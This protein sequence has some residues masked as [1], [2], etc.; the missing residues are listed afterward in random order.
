MVAGRRREDQTWG[1]LPDDPQPGDIWRYVDGEGEPLSAR[2]HA[3]GPDPDS[4][5]H[6]NLTDEVWGYRVPGCLGLGTLVYHTVRSHDDGTVSVRPDDGSSNSILHD[7]GRGCAWH[8]FVEH[9]EWR[10]V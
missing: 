8:G 6:G 2:A 5:V 4:R 3:G 1:T 7:D 10:P 9:C